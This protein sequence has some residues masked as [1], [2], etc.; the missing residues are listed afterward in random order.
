MLWVISLPY[1]AG[2]DFSI[3][4]D[5]CTTYILYAAD[6]EDDKGGFSWRIGSQSPRR[7]AFIP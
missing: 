6:D 2:I 7:E 5:P 1:A 4:H 3:P